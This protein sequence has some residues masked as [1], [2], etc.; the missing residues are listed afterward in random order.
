MNIS[1]HNIWRCWNLFRK[2]KKKTKELRIFEYELEN[3]LFQLHRDLNRGIYKHGQYYQFTVFDNKKRNIVVAPI[4]DRVVHRI[5]YEYLI[6][7]FDKTFIYDVWSCRKGKGLQGA[8]ER[9][10]FFANK[11]AN[12]FVW[13][14]DVKKFFDS[15]NQDILLKCIERRITDQQA[16]QIIREIISS[17]SFGIGIPIG[18]L[19]SQIFSNIYLNEFDRFITHT[20]KP[21]AYLRYGDDF[22]I[23]ENNKDSLEK[24]R[25]QA[26]SFLTEK[27]NLYINSK[28][29]IIIKPKQGIYFIGIDIFP[30]GHRLKKRNWK[31]IVDNLEEKNFSS[32]LGLVKKHSKRKLIK[33]INWR[34]YSLIEKNI[35]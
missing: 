25:T 20:L 29:D 16:L 31:K 24:I 5:I 35:L 6:P 28:N 7:I 30:F 27:M 22:V 23:F 2:G 13:R 9:T 14:A 1:I 10:Q 26:V 18:N 33:E 19:T 12:S 15:V 17:Y 4:R 8:I 32:Y 3:N 11:Y 21:K 34:I